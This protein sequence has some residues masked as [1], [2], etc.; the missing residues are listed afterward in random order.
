MNIE[1]IKENTVYTDGCSNVFVIKIKSGFVIFQRCAEIS[2]AEQLSLR[3]FAGFMKRQVP[4]FD[5]SW[6]KVCEPVLRRGRKKKS[7]HIESAVEN[8]IF[9][10]HSYPA[11]LRKYA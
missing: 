4:D 10:S 2:K 8:K 5:I 9:R 1:E 3:A 11:L 7:L 6:M